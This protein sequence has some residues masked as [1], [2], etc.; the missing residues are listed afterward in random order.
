MQAFRRI[1]KTV[2]HSASPWTTGRTRTAEVLEKRAEETIWTEEGSDRKVEEPA[3][4]T[5]SYTSYFS[6]NITVKI[7]WKI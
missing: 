7:K 4:R 3:R 6:L 2:K 5:P 1:T